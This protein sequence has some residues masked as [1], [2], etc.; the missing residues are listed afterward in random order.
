M[1]QKSGAAAEAMEIV[2]TAPGEVSFKV[3]VK[4]LNR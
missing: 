2:K 1:Q 4:A 3:L